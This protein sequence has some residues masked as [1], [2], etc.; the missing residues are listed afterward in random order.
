MPMTY[1]TLTAPKGA[2][3]SILNWVGY[4]KVD[5]ATVVDE[6]QSLIYSLLRVREMR[7]QWV[8]GVAVGDSK[9]AL[10]SRFLDPAGRLADNFGNRY[11]HTTESSV[12]DRRMYDS[13]LSGSFGTNPFTSGAAGSSTI[14][15][16]LTA[17]GLNQGADITISGAS[18]VDGVTI[19]GTSLVT[20]VIDANTFQFTVMDAAATAGAQTGGGASAT[21]TANNLIASQPMSWAVW[22]EFLQFDAAFLDAT[23][24]RL[25]YYHSLPLLSASNPTNFLTNRYPQLLRVACMASA[26]A[27]MKDDNEE[28]KYVSKLQQMVQSI[29]AESD[30][31][32]MGAD[33]DTETP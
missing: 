29:N 28:Q 31:G 20:S 23:Q 32:Y 7:S 21:Y 3:G 13:L 33:L 4:S 9:V 10:P 24:F 18:T 5:I 6:A 22:D 1:T 2:V 8:F 14:T 25:M 26:A 27:F 15:A 16:T 30:L 11:R 17:H 12:T 19:N